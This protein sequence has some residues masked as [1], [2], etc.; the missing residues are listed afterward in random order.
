MPDFSDDHWSLQRESQLT[1]FSTSASRS[2]AEALCRPSSTG[3]ENGLSTRIVPGTGT[4]LPEV[5]N[6]TGRRIQLLTLQNTSGGGVAESDSLN[7]PVIFGQPELVKPTVLE[8]FVEHCVSLVLGHPFKFPWLHVSQTDVFHGL[9]P[10][11]AS[12]TAVADFSVTVSS[13]EAQHILIQ[14]SLTQQASIAISPAG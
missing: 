1:R 8:A 9:L 7:W 4:S 10:V 5:E 13:N 2:A 12:G 6:P 14:K 11:G 3:L